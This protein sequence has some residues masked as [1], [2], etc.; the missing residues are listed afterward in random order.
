MT[1]II[2]CWGFA[3]GSDCPMEGQYVETFDHDA[4][5]GQGYGVFT[6]DPSKAMRFKNTTD[7]FEFWNKVST[8]K[9]IRKDGK[10][11]KPLTATTVSIERIGEDV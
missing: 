10:P 9:P 7:A 3:D 4:Y 2:Q 5:G 11:N 1:Y 6:S 8:V